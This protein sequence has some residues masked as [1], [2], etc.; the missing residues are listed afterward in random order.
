MLGAALAQW[1][2][3]CTAAVGA[4]AAAW[5]CC[6]RGAATLAP[7]DPAAV[8]L[9]GLDLDGTLCRSDGTV[10][11]RNKAVL[12][13]LRRAGVSIVMATGRPS[14]AAKRMP[15]MVDGEVDFV[16]TSNGAET[17]AAEGWKNLRSVAMPVDDVRSVVERLEEREPG[18]HVGLVMSKGIN[19]Y[20]PSSYGTFAQRVPPSM[21]KRY[22]A[23]QSNPPPHH[24]I[25]RL[26]PLLSP[27][28]LLGT[29]QNRA[30]D[31]A[32]DVL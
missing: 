21:R 1:A 12:A 27:G 29:A 24:L 19:C 31:L 30:A 6:R 26:S 2:R 9:V 10:S 25:V 16:I 20:T 18:V 15:K 17:Y 14:E 28:S 3:P 7:F 32:H 22:V 23:Y 8:G 5:L 4:A 13:A 11:P